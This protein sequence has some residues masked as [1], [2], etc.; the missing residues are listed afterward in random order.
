M[1]LTKNAL[2]KGKNDI[3]SYRI[4]SANGEVYLRPLTQAEVLT[5]QSMT[6]EGLGSFNADNT[7]HGLQTKGKIDI[8]KTTLANGEAQAYAVALSLSCKEEKYT[9][10]E[11]GLFEAKVF[12]E[13]FKIVAEISGIDLDAEKEVENFLKE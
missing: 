12:D 7:R 11:V 10:E 2:L 4:E 9:P 8:K 1:I 6:A 3:K 5:Y 13:I